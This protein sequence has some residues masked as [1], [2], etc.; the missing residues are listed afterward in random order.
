MRRGSARFFMSGLLLAVLLAPWGAAAETK[1]QIVFNGV[2]LGGGSGRL[3]IGE[4]QKLMLEAMRKVM[5]RD[6]RAAEQIYSRIIGMNQGNIDAYLQRGIVRRE[7]KD[8]RGT[9]SDANAVVTLAN[10]TLPVQPANPNLYYQRGMGFRLLRN[11]RQAKQD[12]SRAIQM[13]GQTGWRTDLQAI[14]LEEKGAF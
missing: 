7:L 13:S 2:P 11:F 1:R 5:A 12:I 4:E 6:Y 8:E 9:V 10:S 14:E 3:V